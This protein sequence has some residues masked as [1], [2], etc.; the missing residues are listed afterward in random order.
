MI[1]VTESSLQQE[2]EN[3]MWPGKSKCKEFWTH[4]EIPVNQRHYLKY[5]SILNLRHLKKVMMVALISVS[6]LHR[7]CLVTTFRNIPYNR[8]HNL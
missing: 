6:V 1:S 3:H 8:N 4:F 7:D 2:E 5:E